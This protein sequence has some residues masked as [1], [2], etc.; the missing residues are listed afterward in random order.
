M[1]VYIVTFFINDLECNDSQLQPDLTLLRY[2]RENKGLTGTKEGCASGDCGACTVLVASIKNNEINYQTI[3]SC[4]TPVRALSGKQVITIEHLSNNEDLHPVQDAMV[5][6][7]GSQCGFCTPGFVMSLTG[8]YER[9]KNKEQ[10]ISRSDVCESISGNLCRCTGYRPIVNAGL[11]INLKESSKIF[12]NKNEI[13]KRLTDLST[14]TENQDTSSKD[15]LTHPETSSYLQPINEQSL[16]HYLRINPDARLIAGGTDLMLDVTQAFKKISCFIDLNDVSE[17]TG[18]TRKNNIIQIGSAV[19]YSKLEQFFK[20]LSPS[21]H[22]IFER[23]ASQQIR[24]RG[25][26][27]GNIANASPIADLPPMLL[28]LDATLTLTNSQGVSRSVLIHNFYR[29]YKHTDL[30]KNEYI[31]NVI[32]KEK[33]LADFSRF[34]KVTKRIEDDISTVMLAVRFETNNNIIQNAYIAYGGMAAI[35]LRVSAI[36]EV[37][38][39]KRISD[40]T[41]I[42]TAISFI[43]TQLKPMSDVRASAKYRLDIA[44]ALLHKAWL[45]LNDTPVPLLTHA[46]FSPHNSQTWELSNSE[47]ISTKTKSHLLDGSQGNSTNA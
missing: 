39:N 18:I 9:A 2:I 5:K 19:S 37:F 31:T 25:T 27:G 23:I 46:L 13:K 30:K 42:K 34:F 1:S 36:E 44:I 15:R 26:I 38:K 12:D 41:T 29:D 8:L 6:H 11:S 22:I 10:N 40:E 4:I 14:L 20:P 21:L 47:L 7:H 35:P 17:L 43:K 24:N 16:Q 28:A 45:E 33:N 3:N 32:F